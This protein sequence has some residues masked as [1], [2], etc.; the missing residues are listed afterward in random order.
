MKKGFYIPRIYFA[1]IKKSSGKTTI[2]IAFNR[3]LKDMGFVVQPFKKG[4]DFIDPMW[5]T[6]ASGRSCRNLD[7]FFMDPE[8]IVSYFVSKCKGAN[9][10]TLEGNHGLFDDIHIDGRFSNASMAKLLGVPVVLVIDVKEMGRSVVPLI[11]GCMD[12]DRQLNIAGVILNRIQNERQRKRLTE[13]IEFFT[14]VKVL[15]SIPEMHDVELLQRHLG[16]TATLDEAEKEEKVQ[17]IAYHLKPY[18]DVEAIVERAKGARE[19]KIDLQNEQ[20]KA[21]SF[22]GLRIGIAWDRAFNF[23]YPDNLELLKESGC[24]LVRFSPTD[25]EILPEV[26]GLYIGGGF[27]EL[28]LEQLD[29]NVSM[30]QTIR[31]FAYDGMPVYAECGGLV[32][33]CKRACFSGHTG[34]L[35]GVFDAEVEFKM[36]PVGHGYTVLQSTGKLE[37]IREGIKLKG[38]EFHHAHLTPLEHECAFRVLRGYGLNGE[39]DGAVKFNTLAGFTH[40]FAPSAVEFFTSW[41]EHVVGR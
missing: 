10:A 4:P 41:L 27:P 14:P 13:A 1:A 31:R 35:V 19:L 23:Y 2:A 21:V 20:K 9:F 32:Y 3:I 12:F 29:R 15:G 17:R 5:H 24:D 36:K 11:L 8:G 38:H 6:Q 26:D 39:C 37:W 40:L 30:R 7:F 25:D 34:S 33:L 28:F 16:L 22:K 18:L